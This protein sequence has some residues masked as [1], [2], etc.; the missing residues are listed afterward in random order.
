ML[1]ILVL[2]SASLSRR[3]VRIKIIK[4]ESVVPYD[5]SDH[6]VLV[7]IFASAP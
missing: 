4:V 2:G 1:M 5:A 6:L 3:E 7:L